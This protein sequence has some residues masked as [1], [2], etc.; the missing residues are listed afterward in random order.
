MPRGGPN[1]LREADMRTPDPSALH[2]SPR[3]RG[4]VLALSFALASSP[5]SWAGAA[6]Q[7]RAYSSPEQ[8]ADALAAAWRHG[9]RREILAALGPDAARL[10]DS[11]DPVADRE[12]WGRL[13]AAYDAAHR[14][15]TE[16]ADK[17][18]IVLGKE[19]WPYP[20]PL[21]RQG[22]GW[23]FDVKAGAQQIIDRRIGRD[24][25]NAIE[26]CHAYVEA[27]REY[28]AR[29]PIGD[30]VHDY[31]RR[32]ASVRGKRDGLYWPAA[33]GEAESPLGPLAAAAEAEGFGVASAEGRAPFHGYFYR[34]LT[35]Q[36]KNA[37][38][39]AKDY[40]VKGRMTGGFALVAFPAVYGDS[41][42]MTFIVDR[43]GV[44]FQK[45][46]GP[47]SGAIARAM[48][49]YDPDGTWAPAAP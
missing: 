4:A 18:V 37:P 24:E 40:L 1:P 13:T 46:L 15:E 3:L 32:V 16:G 31:A 47:N 35:R 2:I 26:V 48:S 42:V 30:G 33:A 23:R 20:I 45:N 27:Q 39:G 19:A 9:A 43:D 5:L 36:G 22:Q 25:L 21:V 29:D 14:L 44:V 34:V 8:A 17:A 11:G 49:E 6:A 10:I 41:G 38:G 7:A 28:A 12:A